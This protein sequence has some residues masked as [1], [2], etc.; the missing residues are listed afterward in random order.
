[1]YASFSIFSIQAIEPSQIRAPEVASI[2]LRKQDHS[3]P[4]HDPTFLRLL[5]RLINQST[6]YPAENAAE[7]SAVRRARSINK[8]VPYYT[9]RQMRRLGSANAVP[10]ISFL[11]FLADWPSTSWLRSLRAQAQHTRHGLPLRPR[12]LKSRHTLNRSRLLH[13]RGIKLRRRSP[14][15]RLDIPRTPRMW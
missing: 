14:S 12:G 3:K 11:L 5:Q 8:N 7:C 10:L 6:L 1:M 4:A 9:S 2:V 15:N 13:Q